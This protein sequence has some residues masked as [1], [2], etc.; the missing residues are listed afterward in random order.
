MVLLSV[1]QTD[2]H[3]SKLASDIARRLGTP[4]CLESIQRVPTEDQGVNLFR[5][6]WTEEFQNLGN[7]FVLAMAQEVSDTIR[8]DAKLKIER[9]APGDYKMEVLFLVQSI[10]TTQNDELAILIPLSSDMFT[11]AFQQ[12][13][14]IEKIRQTSYAIHKGNTLHLKGAGKRSVEVG[15]QTESTFIIYGDVQFHTI[16]PTPFFMLSFR[17]VLVL[18]ESDHVV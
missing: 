11:E 3:I 16:P 17:T 7:E 8:R 4:S 14:A 18:V 10:Y 1:L 6:Q 12:L 9:V 13:K 15:L 2:S 5:F